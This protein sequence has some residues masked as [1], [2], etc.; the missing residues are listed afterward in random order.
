MAETS[1]WKELDTCNCITAAQLARMEKRR[2]TYAAQVGAALRRV[3]KSPERRGI[4]PGR[5]VLIAKNGD[6]GFYLTHEGLERSWYRSDGASGQEDR[7]SCMVKDREIERF[8]TDFKVNLA[9]VKKLEQA[10]KA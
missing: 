9:M 5:E 1:S 2:R 4:L 7:Y 8:V 3:L 10:L 6:E